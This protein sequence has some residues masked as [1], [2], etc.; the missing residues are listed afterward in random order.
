MSV[1]MDEPNSMPA[2]LG[3]EPRPIPR[4]LL[5]AHRIVVVVVVV[6]AVYVVLMTLA[7][8][9]LGGHSLATALLLLWHQIY[10]IVT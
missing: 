8:V 1:F 2:S 4:W 5:I 6:L 7:G 10:T 9:F 3:L